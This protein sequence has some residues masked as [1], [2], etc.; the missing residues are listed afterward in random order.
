MQKITGYKTSI[1]SKY[2]DHF[3]ALTKKSKLSSVREMFRKPKE[4]LAAKMNKQSIQKQ[5]YLR[6][7]SNIK[8]YMHLMLG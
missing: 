6:E 5:K 8:N 1:L 7:N 2:L 4:K 3:N